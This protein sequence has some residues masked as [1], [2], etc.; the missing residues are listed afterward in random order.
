[1]NVTSPV[2]HPSQFEVEEI[3]PYLT[4][5]RMKTHMSWTLAEM[6]G[7][8]W[9]VRRLDVCHPSSASLV[10]LSETLNTTHEALSTAGGGCLLSAKASTNSRRGADAKVS[11]LRETFVSLL[12][13]WNSTVAA[14]GTSSSEISSMVKYIIWSRVRGR[15]GEL[16]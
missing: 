13:D 5:V 16:V 8:S 15:V 10:T 2:H 14:V 4:R 9:I 6:I 1:M 12:V 3:D 11:F 7:G